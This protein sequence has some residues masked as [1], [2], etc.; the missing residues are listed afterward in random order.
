M[1]RAGYDLEHTIRLIKGL[2]EKYDLAITMEPGSAVGLGHRLPHQRGGRR[3]EQPGHP[4]GGAQRR[5]VGA[6]AR[7]RGDALQTGGAGRP[8]CRAGRTGLPTGWTPAWPVTTWAIT[9]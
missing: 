5:H 7:L 9:P 8:R 3:H 2:R 6:H 1:T 4:G